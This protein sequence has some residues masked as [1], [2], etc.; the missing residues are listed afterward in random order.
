[1]V[2]SQRRLYHWLNHGRLL[3]RPF[4]HGLTGT[5][6]P[7]G[8]LNI[9]QTLGSRPR[10]MARAEVGSQT[11]RVDPTRRSY[12][13]CTQSASGRHVVYTEHHFLQPSRSPQRVVIALLPSS[14]SPLPNPQLRVHPVPA[15]RPARL[16]IGLTPRALARRTLG[17]TGDLRQP[18]RPQQELEHLGR[19]HR[20]QA[21]QRPHATYGSSVVAQAVCDPLDISPCSTLRSR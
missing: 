7:T 6:V 10:P 14:P 4:D 11:N 19:R 3:H 21:P 8:E 16:P 5:V 17:V 18:R 15:A 2:L 1:M 12:V 13:S 9:G 20:L